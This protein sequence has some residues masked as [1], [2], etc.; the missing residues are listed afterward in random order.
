MLLHVLLGQGVL[1][2]VDAL[3]NGEDQEE[4][5]GKTQPG[6]RG[7]RLGEQIQDGGAEQHQKDGEQSHRNLVAGDGD[8]GRHFPAAFALVLDAQHQHGQAVE[9]EAPDHAEGVGLAQQVH[10]AAAHQDGEDLQNHDQVDDP[11]GG[12]ESRMRLAEPVGEN[13]VFRN[14]VEN[15][16][17]T[18]DRG[19][20]RARKDQEA[21]HHH[22][23]RGKQPQQQRAVLIHGE[24][25]DQVVL[26]N[27]D[28]HRVRND[29]H[30]Q[31]RREPGKDEAVNRDDDGG[32]LQVLQLG[33]GQFAVDLGQRF[34]AAH[35]QHGMAEGDQD[36]ENGEF[37]G[38]TVRQVGVLQKAQR[39]VA[40][41]QAVGSRQRHGLVALLHQGN[42]RP[43]QQ[44][45]HHHRGDLHYPQGLLAGFLNPLGVLPP[46]VRWSRPGQIRPRSS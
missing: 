23:G 42:G 10:V 22:E 35:G 26:V 33:M 31:Q 21:D 3:G 13:A 38:Q 16:V 45:D 41:L 12:A 18:D 19:I 4:R 14:A 2:P 24:A 39:F 34:L 37:R 5:A 15:A 17:G 11:V 1:A 27:R 40:E 8:V 29:H 30:E 43:A 46:E 44:D 7:D 6:N 32:A 28:P 36:A 9:G 25:G 20:D